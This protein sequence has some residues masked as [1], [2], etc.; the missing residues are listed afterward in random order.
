MKFCLH[1]LSLKLFLVTLYSYSLHWPQRSCSK[2]KKKASL[3]YLDATLLKVW[4]QERFERNIMSEKQLNFGL[5]VNNEMIC[6]TP[7]TYGLILRCFSGTWQHVFVWKRAAWRFFANSPC[8]CSTE[9]EKNK[10]QKTALFQ[11]EQENTVLLVSYIAKLLGSML[12]A[13]LQV[14]QSFITAFLFRLSESFIKCFC[15]SVLIFP[16]LAA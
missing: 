3:Q 6:I 2:K 10:K 13:L 1:L 14:L 7:T 12:L 8:F 16:C 15:G 4:L 5:F 9:K 11:R